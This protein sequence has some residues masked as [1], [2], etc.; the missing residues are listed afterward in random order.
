MTTWTL[1]EIEAVVRAA[2]SIDTCDEHDR[3][4]WTAD[5]PERG[6]CV[7]TAWLLHDLLGG[8]L[9]GAEVHHADGS[10]QGYHYWNRLPGGVDV[11][12]TSTQFARGEVVQ[13]GQVVDRGEGLPIPGGPQYVRLR[14]AVLAELAGHHPAK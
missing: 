1:A 3:S 2:W 6:Q 7:A 14:D 12:L 10:L 13:A 11:D 4:D 5:V 8:A 9:V